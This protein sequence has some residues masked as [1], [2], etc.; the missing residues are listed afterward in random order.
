MSMKILM[1]T[2]YF[3]SHR[4]GIEMVAERLFQELGALDQE[5][6]WIASETSPPASSQRRSRLV[7]LPSFNSVEDKLGIPFPIPRLGALRKMRDEIKKT[8]VL[9]I[10]DCLYLTNIAAFLFA[11]WKRVPILV[12]QHIGAG[13]YT[14]GFLRWLMR[15]A[16]TL[17]TRPML[18]RAQQVVFVSETTKR[19]FDKLRF[20]V[21]PAVIFNGVD[22]QIFRP[23][24]PGENKATIRRALQLPAE[25]PVVLFVGRFVEWKGLAVL[26]HMV[27]MGQDYAWAF[28]G[29]GPL[30]PAQWGSPNVRVFRHLSGPSLAELY[31]VC[32]LLVLPSAREGFPL[33]VQEAL[34]SGLPIV[35]GSQTAT[36]DTAMA[37]FVHGV[38]FSA[39]GDRHTAGAF[40]AAI[41]QVLESEQGEQQIEERRRFVNS[42]YS[43]RKATEQYLEIASTLVPGSKRWRP[44]QEPS[45]EAISED[46]R[47]G[48]G[49]GEVSS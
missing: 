12:V 19:Y 4:G 2:H 18:R 15:F 46:R 23:L 36:A 30:D 7:A 33:V 22:T 16:N 10:H 13:A 37:S 8:D 1:A 24:L 48:L 45:P 6:V 11:R 5:I 38:T 43:W 9:V 27:K 21:P 42:R 35:C 41:K 25:G 44:S 14:K 49:S 28:A 40:L 34:A 32:D 29:R 47:T 31:R 26:Q 39:E 20:K 17:I 3:G